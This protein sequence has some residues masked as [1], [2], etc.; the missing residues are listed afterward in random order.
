MLCK[1]NGA[2]SSNLTLGFFKVDGE[3]FRVVIT[4]SHRDGKGSTVVE[5][6]D[7][8]RFGQRRR[9]RFTRTALS[10]LLFQV[11]RGGMSSCR[12]NVSDIDTIGLIAL[13]TMMSWFDNCSRR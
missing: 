8:K 4:A 5:V 12:W 3:P 11:A 2:I 9:C 10:Y 13:S 1:P 7:N 6:G